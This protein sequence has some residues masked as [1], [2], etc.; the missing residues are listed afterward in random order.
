MMK[1]PGF[2]FL[3]LLIA[4]SL[5]SVGM[6]TALQIFPLNRRFLAQSQHT[7]QASFVAQEGVEYVRSLDYSSL[8]TGSFEPNHAVAIV[9]D[10]LSIYSRSTLVELIDTNRNASATDVGLKKVTVT[11]TWLERSLTRS[12]TIATYVYNQ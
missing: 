1:R 5:F 10:P 9:P 2:T 8:T 12:Y 11:V 3:E 7:T 6:V 4:L